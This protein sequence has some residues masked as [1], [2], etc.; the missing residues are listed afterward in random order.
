MKKFTLVFMLALAF[1]FAGFIYAQM[2]L[3]QEYAREEKELL[4]ELEKE[5]ET[6]NKLKKESENYLSDAY[7]E[8]IAR[9]KLGLVRHDEIVF[10]KDTQ[11]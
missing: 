1:V 2:Q 9:E 4:A 11:N 8:K 10:L 3:Y 6:L 7:V 5:T